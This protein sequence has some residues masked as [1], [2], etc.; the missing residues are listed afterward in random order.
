[1]NLTTVA[2]AA[3]VVAG[4][5]A[6]LI[7]ARREEQKALERTRAVNRALWEKVLKNRKPSADAE[8][9]QA[10]IESIKTKDH[11]TMTK[12]VIDRVKKWPQE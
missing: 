3:V 1:M 9:I 2:I 4:F 12:D 6:Y 10:E 5:I 11:E 7:F 8:R